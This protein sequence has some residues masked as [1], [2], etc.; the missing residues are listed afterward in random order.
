MEQEGP[1]KRETGEKKRVRD[2]MSE[3]G[4]VMWP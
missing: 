2:K 3:T 1:R 4:V